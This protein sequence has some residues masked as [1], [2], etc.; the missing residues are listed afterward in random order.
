MWGFGIW[1]RLGGVGNTTESEV[2]APSVSLSS[3]S[4]RVCLPRSEGFRVM[5]TVFLW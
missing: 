3:P 4:V 1:R 2:L 5:I